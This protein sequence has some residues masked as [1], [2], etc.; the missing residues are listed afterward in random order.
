MSLLIADMTSSIQASGGGGGAFSPSSLNPRL[1]LDA[2]SF[3]TAGTITSWFDKSSN[4]QT[5]TGTGTVVTNSQNG[6]S[7]VSFNGTNDLFT[8]NT[9]S[10]C[11]GAAPWAMFIVANCSGFSHNSYPGVATLSGTGIQSGQ[12]ANFGFSNDAANDADFY[13]GMVANNTNGRFHLTNSAVTG[14]C[15]RI[16]IIY[17]GANSAL[18]DFTAYDANTVESITQNGGSGT[19]STPS[20]TIGAWLLNGATTFYFNGIIYEIIALP[21]A[22]SG[23]DLTNMNTYLSTKWGV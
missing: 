21:Q 17:S 19:V 14:T 5:F 1:W 16:T 3:S 23:G 8:G 15:H 11:P 10:I 2:S 6:L 4:L 9:T 20:N 22:V 7:G 18:T 12:G 13:F